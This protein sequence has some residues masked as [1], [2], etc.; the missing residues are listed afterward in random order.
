MNSPEL[1]VTEF[2]PAGQESKAAASNILFIDNGHRDRRRERNA[3]L[4]N[5]GYKVH[6]ARSFE[7]SLS[8]VG[9]G[10]YDLIIASTDAAPDQARQFVEELRRNHPRQKV[11]VLQTAEIELP[12]GAEVVNGDPKQLLER[13]QAMLRPAEKQGP[14]QIAA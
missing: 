1:Q 6:P 9:S 14:E 12:S 13:V 3:V 4:K 2:K 11:L 5:A 10:A 7:Q 8:R